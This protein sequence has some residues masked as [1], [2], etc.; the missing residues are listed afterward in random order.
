VSVEAVTWLDA[1]ASIPG[2]AEK[3]EGMLPTLRYDPVTGKTVDS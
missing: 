3:P 1:Y 2:Y